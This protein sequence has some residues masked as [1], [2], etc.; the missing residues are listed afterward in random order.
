MPRCCWLFR[1]GT[2]ENEDCSFARNGRGRGPNTDGDPRSKSWEADH[3]DEGPLVADRRS[4]FPATR[5]FA[6]CEG[7]SRSFPEPDDESLSRSVRD[8]AGMGENAFHVGPDARRGR[9]IHDQQACRGNDEAAYQDREIGKVLPLLVRPKGEVGVSTGSVSLRKSKIECSH[10][11]S[12]AARHTL[13]N[14]L[15]VP[16]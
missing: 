16:S 6:M 12:L 2:F 7:D 8:Q 10:A 13:G 3:Q 15:S 14:G 9:P 4:G 5:E 11:M 1:G